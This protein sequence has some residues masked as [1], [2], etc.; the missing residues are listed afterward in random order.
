MAILVCPSLVQEHAKYA[1]E[2]LQYFVEK[3]RTLYG[4]EFLVYNTHSMLHI[5]SDAENFGCLE[6]CSAFMFENYL[7][8]LKRMV[9]SGRNPLIQVAKRL[10]ETPKVQK[11]STRAQDCAYILSEG[12]CCEVLQVSDKE[13]RVLCRVYSKPYPLFASPCMS[14]LIGA[15]KFNQINTII[16]WIPRS[17][18]T[19][20]A[21]KINIEERTQIFLSVLHEF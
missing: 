15:Y 8:T 16:K 9:R 11:I 19:K 4:P 20:H 12:K 7:Q 13:E 17:E 1:N 6:N 10:E 5:A 18:L 21:I 3:G 2:L 14:F